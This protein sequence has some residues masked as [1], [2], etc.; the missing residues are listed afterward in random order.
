[1]SRLDIPAPP[2]P[3]SGGECRSRP[4]PPGTD[5]RGAAAHSE[6]PPAGCGGPDRDRHAVPGSPATEQA[7]DLAGD[8]TG[9]TLAPRSRRAGDHH[10]PGPVEQTAQGTGQLV[11]LG[12]TSGSDRGGPGG[13]GRVRLG[14]QP[15][16]PVAITTTSHECSHVSVHQV[17]LG[18]GGGHGRVRTARPASS[19]GA[20]RVRWRLSGDARSPATARTC[21]NGGTSRLRARSRRAR[22]RRSR[23]GTNHLPGTRDRVPREATS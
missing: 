16:W 2:R 15:R 3:L 19:E 23:A 1:V 5:G 14:S 22:R 18:R 10:G 13:Q 17:P 7:V 9:G 21:G 12:A 4:P 11:S 6:V 8:L 20:G